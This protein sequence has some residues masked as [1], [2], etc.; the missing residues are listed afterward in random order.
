MSKDLLANIM[1][2]M[3][4]CYKRNL[5]K[6]IKIFLKNKKKK[7][8]KYSHKYYKYLSKMK[9][10]KTNLLSIEKKIL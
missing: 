9:K 2:K 10:T 5:V 3:K 1:K 7:K 4:K 8:Q 6:D